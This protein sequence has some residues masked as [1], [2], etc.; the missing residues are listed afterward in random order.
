MKRISLA[1]LFTFALLGIMKGENL[2]VT[3]ETVYFSYKQNI[4]IGIDDERLHLP[5]NTE[6]FPGYV[7]CGIEQTN[8]DWENYY[9]ST[10]FKHYLLPAEDKDK[11]E[12][13]YSDTEYSVG[14][15]IDGRTILARSVAFN[16]L[17]SPSENS[18]AMQAN[19]FFHYSP[20]GMV[21]TTGDF[22]NYSNGDSDPK[23]H[24]D[25]AYIYKYCVEK[26]P[27]YCKIAEGE[28]FFVQ[29]SGYGFETMYDAGGGAFTH[30]S[31]DYST[32][33]DKYLWIVTAAG[34]GGY[35]IRNRAT[36]LY[37]SSEVSTH[38]SRSLATKETPEEF[39]F[40]VYESSDS[41]RT[42]Y[43]IQSQE[44]IDRDEAMDA[45]GNSDEVISWTKGDDNNTS[46]WE[47]VP[48][49]GWEY[50]SDSKTLYINSDAVMLDYENTEAR[51]WHYIA[52]QPNYVVFATGITKIGKNTFD[53]FTSLNSIT[54]PETVTTIGESAF[55]KCSSL[56]SITIPNNS[57]TTI[58]YGAF[59]GC[60]SLANITI[61]N[62]VTA[63][64][65]EAFK[66]CIGLT[67][68]KVDYN[69]PYFDSRNNCNAIIEKASNT[70]VA[71][72]KNTVIPENV[73][74]IGVCAFDDYTT[75]TSIRIPR[76][77][78]SI[79]NYAFDDCTG[80]TSIISLIPADQ[81]F[82][83]ASSA[84]NNVPTS[85]TL[86]V[87]AG[88]KETYAATGGWNKFENIVELN[89]TYDNITY[90][91]IPGTENVRVKSV[92]QSATSVSIPATVTDDDITY[93]VTEIGSSAFS[94]CTSLSDIK[95]EGFYENLT[96]SMFN[97][98]IPYREAD[99]NSTPLYIDKYFFGIVNNDGFSGDM[100]IAAGTKYIMRIGSYCSIRKLNIPASVEYIKYDGV[101]G[102]EYDSCYECEDYHW[103]SYPTGYNV[104]AGNSNFSSIDG[105]LYNK[106][107][108][109]LLQCAYGQ[110]AA[111]V[112][113]STV[114]KIRSN[115]LA[116]SIILPIECLATTPPVCESSLRLNSTQKVYVP[117][118]SIDSYL[119]AD[120]WKEC[121]LQPSL[122]AYSD[123]VKLYGQTLSDW[124]VTETSYDVV[125]KTYN[126]DA[127]KGEK[128]SFTFNIDTY[129]AYFKV[130]VDNVH[131]YETWER[132]ATGVFEHI[133]TSSGAHTLRLEYKAVDSYMED[134][135]SVTNLTVARAAYKRVNIS[136]EDWT[137]DVIT[138]NQTSQK[139]YTFNADAGS[140][141]TFDWTTSTEGS[142]DFL[143]CV[144][145]N[146]TILT[147]SGVNNGTYTGTISTGG[148]HTLVC[149][150]SKDGSV[151]GG[152]DQVSVKNIKVNKSISDYNHI[153]SFVLSEI[154]S[155]NIVRFSD[156]SADEIVYRRN[157]TNTNWQALYLPIEIPYEALAEEFEVAYPNDIHQYDDDEDGVIDR[158]EL[159]IIRIKRGTLS[160]DYPYLIRAKEAGV[161]EICIDDATLY[162]GEENSYDCSSMHTQYIFTGTYS[163]VPGSELVSNRYYA[164]S[165]GALSYTTNPE[166]RLSPYRWYL[167]IVSRNG[168]AQPQRISLVMGGEM[169][170]IDEVEC[171][172]DTNVYYDLSGRRI[173][174]PTKGI[175]IVNG[176]KVLVK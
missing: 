86:Y 39:F 155:N 62:S 130:Y 152:T 127:L 141:I 156:L 90:E 78:T 131:R 116:T 124:R 1:L 31:I 170:D 52:E 174:Q 138:H 11:I 53:N 21:N 123:E 81:L 29:G 47:L 20:Q 63:I 36:G 101:K 118:E 109:E 171:D 147:R 117:Q 13:L 159:E 91:I 50:D 115:A 12:Y 148:S 10:T 168:A 16:L 145:D 134:K 14:D 139:R 99:N 2:S 76:S 46:S 151:N 6:A 164:L 176:K 19:N 105:V 66:G 172:E 67:S 26:L 27:D 54:I 111:I 93:N 157:F 68:I 149:T 84:F 32:A 72:C 30:K 160:A 60:T 114:E 110:E 23:V 98:T 126:I 38:S 169:T 104:D 146:S 129:C 65:N 103:V 82:V 97:Y 61:P 167:K 112:I 5:G 133:F 7:V 108:T 107:Q 35:Y 73:T 119:A 102:G 121:Y 120:Y 144:L 17:F 44:M 166:A 9:F 143:T 58:G 48:N 95:I 77:V 57:V 92:N 132:E 4:Q 96:A 137:S 41:K 51:P 75:L 69:N 64:E 15:K 136:F 175:Y 71:G 135:I 79:R 158:T 153:D 28:Y 125:S 106:Q 150:Y 173:E 25:G 87:P 40:T 18:I 154:E 83:P 113:P 24:V 88:A 33:T 42:N 162:L 3:T 56:T 122:S 94:G 37:L 140:T 49:F 22:Y 45:A 142:Y 34:N 163:G 165:S 89:F 100:N 8:A 59:S 128:L 85:C 55:Y 74:T 161:K 70:L 43:W 80:L